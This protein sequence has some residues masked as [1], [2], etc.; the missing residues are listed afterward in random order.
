M[1]SG[2]MV[3][4]VT[5]MFNNGDLDLES[6]RAL[7]EWHIISGTTALIVVGTTGEAATLTLKE[8]EQLIRAVVDQ[9]NSRVPVIA[10]AGAVSTQ[11]TIDLTFAAMELGVD[12]C[13]IM[14]PPYVKPTQEG[15]YL[16]Y[17]AIADAVAVPQ[18]LYNVPGRTACDILPETVG[19]L[20]N[21]ANIVGVKE[22]SGDI[23]RVKAILNA[24]EGKVDVYS[25]EDNL[26]LESVLEYGAKGVISV[27]ANI[28]PELMYQMINYALAGNA[29]RATALNNRL[30]TLHQHLFCE[31]N[32]IPAKW[33]LEQM[34][35]ISNGI[36]LPLTPLDKSC[37]ALVRQAMLDAGVLAV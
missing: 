14:A 15:L 13:L 22:S 34:K 35:K 17:K 11:A 25:G 16:H 19:R 26:A 21:I 4:L 5:P 18:I 12:A 8:R 32:P 37:H 2:S 28:A 6:L 7:V 27:T 24:T 23:S 20:A 31:S 9:A 33:A 3:A 29:I 30:L 1:F 36:R 10:G